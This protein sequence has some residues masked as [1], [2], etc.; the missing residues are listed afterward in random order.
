MNKN[1]ILEGTLGNLIVA[2]MEETHKQE[3]HVLVSDAL[4]DLLILPQCSWKP[5]N[6]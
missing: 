4:R 1:K 3:L 2:L 5:A 6:E